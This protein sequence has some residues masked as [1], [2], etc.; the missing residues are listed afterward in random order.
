MASTRETYSEVQQNKR[1]G[2][3]NFD[4]EAW[5][6]MIEPLT[7]RTKFMPL[8]LA[9]AKVLI[10]HYRFR[11]NRARQ[12]TGEEIA[13]LR[14]LETSIDS[15]M[16]EA[17]AEFHGSDEF[18]V[19]LSSRSPKDASSVSVADYERALE[20]VTKDEAYAG[21]DKADQMN[22]QM[23]AV[24]DAQSNLAVS[25]G[26]GAMKLL[27]ASE[28]V[29]VDLMDATTTDEL[30]MEHP[31]RVV[32][33][34]WEPRLNHRMEFR[35]FVCD[36]QFTAVSQ[37][38]HYCFFPEVARRADELKV[39]L[40]T[41]WQTE[42]RDRVTFASYVVD[43]AILDGED[44]NSKI[45]VIELN[46]FAETTGGALFDWR[47]DADVLKKGPFTMRTWEAARPEIVDLVEY[48]VEQLYNP[49]HQ[50]DM[51]NSEEVIWDTNL[52]SLSQAVGPAARNER[53]CLIS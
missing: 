6:K 49:D 2:H 45:V 44:G 24:S 34:T 40:L 25:D 32:I 52:E 53:R 39:L 14:A 15:T 13:T 50:D 35:G 18:F 46:P 8:E 9:Q 1:K 26:R 41:F 42:V 16:A 23:V 33:R 51:D 12:L 7:F 43:F 20:A 28:R 27:T 48:S 5:Y 38:N 19:R 31:M 4:V 3:L 22:R 11:Y 30:Y 21:T 37:Y 47:A 17:R 36:G 29:F 10:A